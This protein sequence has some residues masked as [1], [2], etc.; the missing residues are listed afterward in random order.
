MN[1]LGLQLSGFDLASLLAERVGSRLTCV[2]TEENGAL[3]A[4]L[5]APDTFILDGAIVVGIPFRNAGVD[6]P[7]RAAGLSGYIL[8]LVAPEVAPN[9]SGTLDLEL[10]PDKAVFLVPPK[11]DG[12]DDQSPRDQS[13]HDAA[14][15]LVD[16]AQKAYRPKSLWLAVWLDTDGVDALKAA[17][18]VSDTKNTA[19]Q[20][21]ELLLAMAVATG[22]ASSTGVQQLDSYNA[23]SGEFI[24][25]DVPE[26][27]GSN[28]ISLP[29]IDLGFRDDPLGCITQPLGFA[30]DPLAYR[31]VIHGDPDASP[32]DP[33]SFVGMG[34]DVVCPL[35]DEL[36]ENEAAEQLLV[37]LPG[38][39]TLTRLSVSHNLMVNAIMHTALRNISALTPL[40][41]TPPFQMN[42]TEHSAS[43]TGSLDLV[44]VA[45]RNYQQ[46]RIVTN[47]R[48]G[49]L[50]QLF[51]DLVVLVSTQGFTLL[52]L[53]AG[54][55]LN[56]LPAHFNTFRV[57][58]SKAAYGGEGDSTLEDLLSGF[59]NQQSPN[60]TLD[61]ALGSWTPDGADLLPS[62][63]TRDRLVTPGP[64]EP[65]LLNQPPWPQGIAFGGLHFVNGLSAPS[66]LPFLQSELALEGGGDSVSI[67]SLLRWVQQVLPM[68]GTEDWPGTTPVYPSLSNS[69]QDR[70]DAATLISF[71]M[72]PVFITELRSAVLALGTLKALHGYPL[73]HLHNDPNVKL[74]MFDVR[75][76][77]GRYDISGEVTTRL[78]DE[79]G[80]I[81]TDFSLSL[82]PEFVPLRRQRFTLVPSDLAVASQ[83]HAGAAS[84]LLETFLVLLGLFA[85]GA[86]G[87]AAAA[88]AP[89]VAAKVVGETIQGLLM[90]PLVRTLVS[91]L[92]LPVTFAV[93]AAGLVAG[94]AI[95]PWQFWERV[96]D[97]PAR[98]KSD[99]KVTNQVDDVPLTLP[100]RIA[101]IAEAASQF[102][103]GA[104]GLIFG[105]RF[106]ALL[107]ALGGSSGSGVVAAV[108]NPPPPALVLPT[109]PPATLLGHPVFLVDDNDALGRE[110]GLHLPLP[111]EIRALA[112]TYDPP[113]ISMAYPP[114]KGLVAGSFGFGDLHAALQVDG[115]GVLPAPHPTVLPWDA[116]PS[117]SDQLVLA[118]GDG[119]RHVARVQLGGGPNSAPDGVT[120]TVTPFGFQPV[121]LGVDVT[122]EVNTEVLGSDGKEH[123][124][125]DGVVRRGWRFTLRPRVTGGCLPTAPSTQWFQWFRL[126]ANGDSLFMDDPGPG[127]WD[128][129]ESENGPVL[130]AYG[131]SG[132][133]SLDVVTPSGQPVDL[134]FRAS[135][136]WCT[137][138]S[139]HNGTC[140]DQDYSFVERV[141]NLKRAVVNQ[142][143]AKKDTEKEGASA[144]WFKGAYE[145]FFAQPPQQMADGGSSFYG[146]DTDSADDPTPWTSLLETQ[147]KLAA[148]LAQGDLTVDT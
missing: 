35:T 144:Q 16:A 97:D 33:T 69:F 126:N 91:V 101:G 136:T 118:V 25:L 24:N 13:P 87:S 113:G 47:Q 27:T 142:A 6:L 29:T 32:L 8:L 15:T 135:F 65:P 1:D 67:L 121:E 53:S 93:G 46:V 122:S 49:Q 23:E 94:G 141:V 128:S 2:F 51:D 66:L 107:T 40:E 139:N 74:T 64:G 84:G 9:D 108:A 82:T 22:I 44:S 58:L 14:K 76:E 99:K 143:K 50:L 92:G 103:P 105:A 146:S 45:A 116:L 21:G 106:Q 100:A 17:V 79:L 12:D 61:L 52:D 95:M 19:F 115:I 138:L 55:P 62:G 7:P 96:I 133:R 137:L 63:A 125:S 90:R 88:S 72:T 81:E 56:T 85:G 134:Q 3:D 147:A 120:M 18:G 80:K 98:A 11:D 127:M 132:P 5:L 75:W 77:D 148:A 10:V 28:P 36:T 131:L 59:V 20:L 130:F 54:L 117:G 104:D 26:Y 114:D 31:W 129:F 89:V 124:G 39:P 30:N 68:A 110:P 86:V 145:S 83:F 42:A 140:T 48:V 57:E 71:A 37:P 111:L 109:G 43:L 73:G 78:G 34:F 70:P 4:V 102:S 38:D 41:S 60:N 119:G 112:G 123:L